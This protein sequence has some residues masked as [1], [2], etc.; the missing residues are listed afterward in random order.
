MSRALR[1]TVALVALF[2]LV[3]GVVVMVRAA[4]GDYQG[5]YALTGYFARAGEGLQP[6]SSVAFRGV[7]VGRVHAITLDGDR[8]KIS[9]LIQP[10]FKVPSDATAT[11]RSINLFGAEQISLTT[12]G[13]ADTPP[14]LAPGSTVGRTAFSD[15]L[16][17]LFAAAAPLLQQVNTSNLSSVIGELAQASQGEGPRIAQ[18]IGAGAALAGELDHTLAAQLDAFDS[19]TRFTESL[20]PDGATINSLSAATQ[21]ALP[22]FNAEVGDYQRLLDSL[23]PFANHLATLLADY[24]PDIAT[25]LAQGDNVARILLAQQDDVG[26]VIHG[27]YE[28]TLKFAQ[29]GSADRLPD[30]SRYAYFNTFLLFSDVNNFVCDLLTPKQAGLSFLEPLQQALAGAGSAFDCSSQISAFD[31]LQQAAPGAPTPAGPTPAAAPSSSSATSAAQNLA[32]QAYGLLGKPAGSGGAA[33]L[34]G[35]LNGLLGGL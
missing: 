4:N 22:S 25:L 23:T 33:G 31:Q 18:S 29:G 17:D 35:Y 34:G 13:G 19:F 20:A 3:V 27:A 8:A 12:P 5:D 28:Y 24:H 16:G 26:Q 30:G 21:A 7:Q 6:G 1:A 10:G 15:E 9:M 14:Y 11:V 2:A 32:T